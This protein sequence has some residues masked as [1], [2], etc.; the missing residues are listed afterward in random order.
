[1]QRGMCHNRQLVISTD[2]CTRFR[3]RDFYNRIRLFTRFLYATY[4]RTF[5]V[6]P[7]R[8]DTHWRCKLGSVKGFQT[9]LYPSL[10]FYIY[11]GIL[12]HIQ[13]FLINLISIEL[14][15]ITKKSFV[16]CAYQLLYTFR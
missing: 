8:Q 7:Y 12:K 13:I 11:P 3:C 6:F 10:T 5:C 9:E 14:V 2:H 16:S 1:M 15:T 4:S